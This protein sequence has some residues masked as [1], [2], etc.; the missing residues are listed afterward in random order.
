MIAP[1]T[2]LV[3][4]TYRHSL[5]VIRS[6]SMAGHRVIAAIDDKNIPYA[7]HSR[8][9]HAVWHHTAME[10]NEPRFDEE[11]RSFVPRHPE[12]TLLLP[13]GDA[14]TR[15]L[16]QNVS[17]VPGHVK[18]LMPSPEIVALCHNKLEMC[19]SH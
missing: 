5:T 11:F 15:F 18:P 17:A 14:E 1:Q 7:K 13:M 19:S 3:L 6:L 9:S 4:G 12:V 16:A 2:V 10:G 8:Y